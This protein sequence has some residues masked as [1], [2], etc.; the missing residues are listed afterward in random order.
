[1]ASKHPEIR[2]GL[3]FL[4]I[5]LL[6][7]VLWFTYIPWWLFLLLEGL[8]IFTTRT[9]SGG[10]HFRLVKDELRDK[11]IIVTGANTG[12]GFTTSLGLA[13]AGATV[14]LACRSDVLFFKIFN[15]IF[16]RT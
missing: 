9:T 6:I 4:V 13:N 8:T 7:L 12:I 1:M 10:K 2:A 16:F 11:V 15:L 3:Y 14:Y 5:S